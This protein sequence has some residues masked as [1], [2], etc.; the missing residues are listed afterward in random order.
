MAC[1]SFLSIPP[2]TPLHFF[3]LF[4]LL[5]PRLDP[6]NTLT[7]S[8]FLLPTLDVA[9][10]TPPLLTIYTIHAGSLID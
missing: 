4:S 3:S 5:T 10:P 8:F 9:S 7:I 2:P 6:N 1:L